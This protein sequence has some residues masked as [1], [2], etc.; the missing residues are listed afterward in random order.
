MATNDLIAGG[1]ALLNLATGHSANKASKEYNRRLAQYQSA[2]NE[3]YRAV[4]PLY[5]DA[6]T[7]TP[8]TVLVSGDSAPNGPA[9]PP[10][11]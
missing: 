4:Q 5:L 8:L 6:V 1:G 2:Q 7:Q 9:Y 10:I 11:P 3:T